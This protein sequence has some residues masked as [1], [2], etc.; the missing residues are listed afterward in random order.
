MGKFTL[1]YERF[2][3]QADFRNELCSQTKVPLYKILERIIRVSII[4]YGEIRFDIRADFWN[5]LCSQTKVPLY[6]ILER[7]IRVSII[8]YGEIR[9][10]IRALWITSRFPE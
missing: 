10:D 1:I 8:S 5:E 6:K 4:S 7:I 9:F 3:L 2:G